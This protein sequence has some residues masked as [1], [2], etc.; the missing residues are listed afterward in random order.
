M[1]PERAGG[2][3]LCPVGDDP[4]GG[5]KTEKQV[6]ELNDLVSPIH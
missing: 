2:E 1:A 4:R 5:R 6:E 3:M